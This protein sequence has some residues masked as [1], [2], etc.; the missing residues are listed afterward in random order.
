MRPIRSSAIILYIALGSLV[1][2]AQSTSTPA[3][4]A[5]PA[6]PAQSAPAPAAKPDQDQSANGD[7]ALHLGGGDL[8]E[9]GVY[10]VPDLT[11]KGRISNEGEFYMPLVGYLKI[12]GMS[13]E[14]AQALI[15]KRYVDGNFLRSPHVTINV[16]EYVTQGA[17]LLG[18]IAHPGIFPVLG[19]RRLFDIISA[20]GGFTTAAGRTVTITHRLAP[21]SPVIVVISDTPDKATDANVEI[22]PGDTI[23]VA[24]AET[25]YVV[26]EVARPAGIQM[27][28]RGMTVLKALALSGGPS[29]RA[30]LDGAKLVRKTESGTQEIAVPLKQILSA[31]A[32]DIEMKPDDILFVPGRN[33][34]AIQTILQMAT[35]LAIRAPL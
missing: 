1:A 13:V 33:A 23:L 21:Q 6:P 3:P 2:C 4:S 9:A 11:S 14:E 29:Q 24:K 25:V 8:I 5:P 34:L 18:E 26:G 16:L 28:N 17:S 32:K 27:D 31:K 20:A 12:G 10:G 22:F 19:S 7:A 30:K 15:E 35:G